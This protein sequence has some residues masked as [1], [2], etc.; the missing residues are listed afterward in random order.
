MGGETDDYTN[1][2]KE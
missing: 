1:R 2:V